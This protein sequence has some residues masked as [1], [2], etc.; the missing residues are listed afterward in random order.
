MDTPRTGVRPW[1]GSMWPKHFPQGCP[2]SD[3]PDVNGQVY[4]LVASAT[5]VSQKD[6]VSHAEKCRK[7]CNFC[8]SVSPCQ[9]AALSSRKSLEEALR[10]LLVNQRFAGIAVATLSPE[11]GKFAQTGEPTHYSLWLTADALDAAIGLFKMVP[12]EGDE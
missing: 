12:V 1:R 3:V 10:A 4:R 7:G 5:G 6:M 2:G 8:R 9:R 11:Q